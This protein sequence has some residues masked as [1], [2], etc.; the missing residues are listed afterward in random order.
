[1][2]ALCSGVIRL[3]VCGKGRKGAPMVTLCVRLP[4][5]SLV[6]NPVSCRRRCSNARK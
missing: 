6:K 4:I 2:K 5:T 1:M 3:K